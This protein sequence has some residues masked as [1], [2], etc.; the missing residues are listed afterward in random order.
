LLDFSSMPVGSS[1]RGIRL[2]GSYW[3]IKGLSIKGAGDNGMNISGSNDIIEYCEFFENQDSGC[4]LG[5]GAANNQI[6]NCD[7]YYNVDP[8]QGN[9]DGFSPKLDVGTGNYFRGCRSW[10]NSDDGYDGY[11]R[12]SDDITTTYEN[13]W[14]YKNGYLKDGSA[15]TGN[16]NGFKMGGSDNKDLRHNAILKNCLSVANRVKGFDQNNDVGSMT[17][18]NCTAFN[19]GTNYKIDGTILAAGKALTVTN[20]ISAGSGA[21]SLTGGVMTTNSWMTPFSVS[22]AD[23]VSVDPSAVIAARKADGSLPDITFMHLAAGSD[24]IDAGTNVGLPYRGSKPDLGC[25][26]SGATKN[27]VGDA[28]ISVAKDMVFIVD[29]K[30]ILRIPDIAN[31]RGARRISM[32]TVSGKRI[33]D[34]TFTSGETTRTVDCSAFPPG[35]YLIELNCGNTIAN[36]LAVVK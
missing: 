35:T 14:C 33:L 27:I 19:N 20:C 24:L 6:I 29:D 5:G 31:G 25:F 13:C 18:Y 1:N 26:E 16:G 17:L 2:S 30:R 15:S 32:F 28:V 12:P 4:Q 21:V 23:F 9:A 34:C 8:G 36:R 11:L 7:S 10:Q 3:H 22:N